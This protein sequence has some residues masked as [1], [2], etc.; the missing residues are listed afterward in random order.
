M[1]ALRPWN[2]TVLYNLPVFGQLDLYDNLLHPSRP[3]LIL[4]LKD[5]FTNFYFVVGKGK[6]YTSLDVDQV[7]KNWRI[8]P[9]QFLILK[10]E[11]AAVN[12][13]LN[14]QTAEGS[15]NDMINNAIEVLY[16]TLLHKDFWVT[17]KAE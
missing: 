13:S 8:T 14:P 3:E 11:F 9:D 16:Q 7:M 1:S 4:E 2:L 6:L 15:L 10:L 5:E 12:Y 17:V